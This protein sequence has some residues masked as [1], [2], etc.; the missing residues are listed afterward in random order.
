MIQIS[1][2][3]IIRNPS[4]EE[5]YW[6]SWEIMCA[7][8][9]RFPDSIL[10]NI[11]CQVRAGSTVRQAAASNKTFRVCCINLLATPTVISLKGKEKYRGNICNPSFEKP[12]D[13]YQHDQEIDPVEAFLM[14]H[15]DDQKEQTNTEED[16][17]ENDY[18]GGDLYVDPLL[19]LGGKIEWTS[20][21]VNTYMAE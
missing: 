16:P 20:R 9:K 15:T 8:C 14:G 7:C 12:I 6:V 21:V 19:D 10:E 11:R 5:E 17:M 18:V 3:E 4:L 13:N 1:A 2:E